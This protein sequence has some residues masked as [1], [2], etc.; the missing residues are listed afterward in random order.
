[1]VG[2]TR[3]AAVGQADTAL[4]EMR[5]I[6]FELMR[7]CPPVTH[8]ARF[9]G[10]ATSVVDAAGAGPAT[11]I[12]NAGEGR[13][14]RVVVAMADVRSDEELDERADGRAEGLGR[15]TT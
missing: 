12:D 11:L 1:M 9:L 5:L 13:I 6:E 8:A 10:E 3:G 15:A 7:D 4:T 2:D 14:E